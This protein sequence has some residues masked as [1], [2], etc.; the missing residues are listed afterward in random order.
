M[1]NIKHPKAD[2]LATVL[3]HQLGETVTEV[4]I[5]ALQEKLLREQRR[6]APAEMAKSL[7]KI[8]RRCAALPN[9]DTRSAEDIIEY[10]S[11]GLPKA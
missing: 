10:D 11:K 7:L 3:A 6:R 4:V 1:L 9:Q 5:K 2:R 8:G